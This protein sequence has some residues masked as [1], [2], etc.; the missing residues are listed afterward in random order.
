MHKFLRA[1]SSVLNDGEFGDACAT[2]DQIFMR[3]LCFSLIYLDAMGASY[4]VTA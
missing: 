1:L 2:V 3:S 4:K